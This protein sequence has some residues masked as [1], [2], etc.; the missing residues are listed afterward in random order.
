MSTCAKGD[1]LSCRI[2]GTQDNQNDPSKTQSCLGE[3]YLFQREDTK[4][5]R[6]DATDLD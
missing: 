3:F 4:H 6:K 5:L 2:T 1:Q